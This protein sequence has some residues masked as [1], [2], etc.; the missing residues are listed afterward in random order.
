M[1]ISSHDE[2]MRPSYFLR[3]TLNDTDLFVENTEIYH[4][5]FDISIHQSLEKYKKNVSFR[6]FQSTGN[7]EK[8]ND[9][10]STFVNFF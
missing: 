5:Q 4:K 6:T 2:I 7:Y 1:E 9:I 8:V 10:F 3:L